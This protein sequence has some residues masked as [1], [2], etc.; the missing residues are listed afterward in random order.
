MKRMLTY[1][2][3]IVVIVPNDEYIHK[4]TEL[5]FKVEIVNLKAKSLNPLAD[6]RL[7]IQYYKL[8][9]KL[10]PDICFFYYH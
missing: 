5:D 10:K 3:E 4:L 7:L 9:A 6:L 2:H 1:G 8:L